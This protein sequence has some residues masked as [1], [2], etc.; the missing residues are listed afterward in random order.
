MGFF[1]K[2]LKSLNPMNAMKMLPNPLHPLQSVQNLAQSATHPFQ[3]AQNALN[4]ATHPFQSAMNPLQT[5]MNLTP[6]MGTQSYGG[7][8]GAAQPMAP[9]RA[10]AM[11]NALM[12]PPD[13]SAYSQPPQ[14]GGAVSSGPQGNTNAMIG[15][16]PQPM[17]PQ[18]GIAQQPPQPAQPAQQPLQRQARTAMV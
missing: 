6:G 13:M 18:M 11:S 16:S 17:Q 2:A 5:T 15:L 8:G 3:T 14:M 10:Q 4:A 1:K 12:A 7:G 9:P